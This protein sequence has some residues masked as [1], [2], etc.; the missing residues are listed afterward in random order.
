MSSLRLA[1]LVLLVCISACAT[2]DREKEVYDPFEGLNRK[3]FAF[4]KGVDKVVLE[5][6][7]K[8]YRKITP[9]PV[10]TGIGNFLHNLREPVNFANSLLQGEWRNAGRSVYRFGVN[11]IWGLFGFIDVAKL[12]GFPYHREDF[13]QTLAVYGVSAGPYLVLPV[14]GPSNIRDFAGR[15]ADVQMHPLSYADYDGESYVFWGRP[16]LAGLT[17]RERNLEAIET[18]RRTAL[19]EYAQT[20]S[21]YYQIRQRQITNAN[22]NVSKNQ[23]DFNLLPENLPDF[24]FLPEES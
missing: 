4:N 7:A 19:D 10:R 22:P 8:A 17:A 9:P 15:F 24:N 20:R 2:T 5:P 3:V 6:A 14:F 21:L 18:L 16:V 11:S 12:E 23:P 1:C 13:G